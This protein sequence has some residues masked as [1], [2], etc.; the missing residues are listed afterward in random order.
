[1]G[2]EGGKCPRAG[3]LRCPKTMMGSFRSRKAQLELLSNTLRDLLP[4][5]FTKPLS[6]S[7]EKSQTADLV[8]F[9]LDDDPL[10]VGRR[11][12]GVDIHWGLTHR[13]GNA[14]QVSD[15]TRMIRKGHESQLVSREIELTFFKIHK[16]PPSPFIMH[17]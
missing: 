9:L 12:D 6:P 11:L 3:F 8:V 2:S 5:I 13:Q 7:N 4:V 14:L 17:S 1:M 15:P 16:A 10:A